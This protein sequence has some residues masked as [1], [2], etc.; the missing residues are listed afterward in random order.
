VLVTWRKPLCEKLSET[1]P[2]DADMR[3]ALHRHLAVKLRPMS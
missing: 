2:V 1:G 3:Q